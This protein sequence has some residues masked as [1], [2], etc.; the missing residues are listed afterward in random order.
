LNIDFL[1]SDLKE[2]LKEFAE[3]RQE[4]NPDKL[5]VEDAVPV[6]VVDIL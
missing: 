2:S 3:Q 1:R 6:K 5:G 4:V